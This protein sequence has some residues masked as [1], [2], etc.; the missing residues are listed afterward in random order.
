[1]TLRNRHNLQK[2][3]ELKGASTCKVQYLHKGILLPRDTTFESMPAIFPYA[4]VN[5]PLEE[6]GTSSL[7]STVYKHHRFNA[8]LQ[9]WLPFPDSVC[10]RRRYPRYKHWRGDGPPD[11]MAS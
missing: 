6:Y 8:D 10:A 4:Y 7:S 11:S 3:G 1:M 2:Q 9:K 5:V